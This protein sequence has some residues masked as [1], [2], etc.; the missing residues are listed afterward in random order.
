MNVSNSLGVT[1]LVPITITL[2]PVARPPIVSNQ[3]LSTPDNITPGAN[4][5]PTLTASQPLGLSFTFALTDAT[6]TWGVVPTT[7]VVYLM[8]GKTL[9]FSTTPSYTC[10]IIV[11]ASNSLTAQ[12]FLTINLSPT[13]RPPVFLNGGFW[14]LTVDEGT[15]AGT[16][17]NGG[18]ALSASDPNTGEPCPFLVCQ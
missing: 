12:A 14:D 18:A 9:S 3:V 1:A 17:L 2:L 7:G 13:N 16:I 10:T 8:P 11:T 4:L 5:S 15:A 6:G